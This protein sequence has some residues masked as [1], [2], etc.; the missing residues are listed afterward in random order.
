MKLETVLF[1]C[2]GNVGVITINRP[3]EFNALNIELAD[4][5]TLAV[6]ECRRSKQVRSIIL[7]G[8][9]KSFCSG[10]DLS[11]G[12][13]VLYTDPPAYYKQL[14]KSLNRAIL[15]I[16]QSEKVV[17][18][19]INGAVG[20]AG[21]SIAMACDLKIAVTTAKFKQAYTSLGLVPDGGWTVFVPQ[22]IGW[23]KTAELVFLDP[24]INADQA[25]AMGLVNM[26]VQPEKLEDA[27]FEWANK[28]AKG[29]TTAFGMAKKLINES[30][31]PCLEKQ[32]EMERLG[33]EKAGYTEDYT[34]GLTAFFEKRA[35]KFIGE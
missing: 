26:V 21:F 5:L 15:E 1:E 16:R 25:F 14:T 11:K 34:E 24:I 28:L 9:G 19:A 2:V 4:D 18:G 20:G 27:A 17:I 8:T 35:P 30:I 12:K 22:L 7:K 29:A 3:K 32:I 13:E 31:M 6:E 10:G 33:V 23:G